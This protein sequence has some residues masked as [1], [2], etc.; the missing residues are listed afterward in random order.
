MKKRSLWILFISALLCLS[1]LLAACNSGETVDT[2]GTSETEPVEEIETETGTEKEEIPEDEKVN[3][4]SILSEWG[5]YLTSVGNEAKDIYTSATY[6][7]TEND[8]E[9]IDVEVDIYGKI[10]E[11]VK[12]RFASYDENDEM[13]VARSVETVFYNI[14]TGKRLDAPSRS[15]YVYDFEMHQY[16]SRYDVM[17]FG[18]A[19]IEITDIKYTNLGTEEEPD[20][21]T[22]ITYSYYDNDGNVLA[23][24]LENDDR[25]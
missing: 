21:Q 25:A 20:W 19:I 17:T 4:A 3:Y 18:N 24:G 13:T 7:F 6:L 2:E 5:K 12:T 15:G 14:E 16:V 23:S 11:V 22:V 9:S 8:S 1:M 10:A